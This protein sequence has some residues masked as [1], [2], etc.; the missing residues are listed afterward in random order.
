MLK[1]FGSPQTNVENCRFMES[2][3][4]QPRSVEKPIH[5]RS[6]NEKPQTQ[7]L[8]KIILQISH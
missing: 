1:S 6:A 4:T 8:K 7:I 2:W 3:H 5:V